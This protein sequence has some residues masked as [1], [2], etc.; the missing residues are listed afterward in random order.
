MELTIFSTPS[1]RQE[2]QIMQYV[3]L[4][5]IVIYEDGGTLLH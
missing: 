5:A 1:K 3:D 4:R 2:G